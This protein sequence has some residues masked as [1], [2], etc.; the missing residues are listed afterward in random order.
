MPASSGHEARRQSC[1]HHSGDEYNHRSTCR[2]LTAN[3]RSQLNAQLWD[4]VLCGR[5]HTGSCVGTMLKALWVLLAMFPLQLMFPEAIDFKDS[6]PWIG[7][8]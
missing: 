8:P 7:V 4:V 2:V 3:R 5:T 6:K 1:S